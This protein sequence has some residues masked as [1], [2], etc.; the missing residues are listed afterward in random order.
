MIIKHG[1]HICLQNARGAQRFVVFF[2]LIVLFRCWLAGQANHMDPAWWSLFT[3]DKNSQE[4]WYCEVWYCEVWYCEVWYCE[5]W[6]CEVWYCEVWYCEVWYCV[7]FFQ[8]RII[9]VSRGCLGWGVYWCRNLWD[10]E[11]WRATGDK[12]VISTFRTG[13]IMNWKQKNKESTFSNVFK[14]LQTI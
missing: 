12:G 11:K 10:C 5:V 4:V 13:F 8:L 6:Y 9:S 7:W 1:R 3:A 2:F 14:N